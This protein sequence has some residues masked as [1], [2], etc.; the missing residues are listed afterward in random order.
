MHLMME[1][2]S[3]F[4][5]LLGTLLLPIKMCNGFTTDDIWVSTKVYSATEQQSGELH[6]GEVLLIAS[7]LLGVKTKNI[8]QNTR[9]MHITMKHI[10]LTQMQVN[11][12]GEN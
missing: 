8:Y 4:K 7:I 11:L 6:Q 12:N 2:G 10:R 1:T 9:K 5:Q 3:A